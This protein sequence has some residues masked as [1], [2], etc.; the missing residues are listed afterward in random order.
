ME[1]EISLRELISYKFPENRL[2]AKEEKSV[3]TPTGRKAL[4]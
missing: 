2:P 1:E 3:S 4:A